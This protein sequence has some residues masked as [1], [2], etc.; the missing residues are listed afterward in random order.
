MLQFRWMLSSVTVKLEAVC[1]NFPHI[2]LTSTAVKTWKTYNSILYLGTRVV[3]ELRAGFDQLPEQV[4]VNPRL[5][6]S[7]QQSEGTYQFGSSHETVSLLQGMCQ[8]LGVLVALLCAGVRL[9][10]LGIG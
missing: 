3:A 5:G 2:I 9:D 4:P 6:R 1:C 8:R 7:V 10:K